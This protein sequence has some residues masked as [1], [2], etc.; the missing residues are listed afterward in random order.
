MTRSFSGGGIVLVYVSQG[1]GALFPLLVAPLIVRSSGLAEFGV[2]AILLMCA[3]GGALISE[4]SFDAYGPRLISSRGGCS[5][6]ASESFW[7][8]LAVKLV[9]IPFAVLAAIVAAGVLVSGEM[10][11]AVAIG[12]VLHVASV[13]AQAQWHLL[14]TNQP[15]LLAAASIVSRLFSLA[16][17]VVLLK[18]GSGG[19]VAFFVATCAGACFGAVVA[20]AF[21]R[22]IRGGIRLVPRM[23]MLIAAAPAFIGVA[24]SFVQNFVGQ[25]IAGSIGGPSGAGAFAAVDRIA[26]GLSAGLKPIFMVSY[27]RMA[28]MHVEEP[29]RGRRLVLQVAVCWLLI[30]PIVV[31]LAVAFGDELLLALYG[32]VM[33]GH[34]TLLAILVGWLCIGILNNVLG[35]QGILA[36]GWDRQYA[37]AMWLGILAAVTSGLVLHL[38][39]GLPGAMIA[40]LSV[41]AGEVAI[42]AYYAFWYMRNDGSSLEG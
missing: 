32:Q 14:S 29:V 21:N 23:E 12:I 7:D 16:A 33:S 41:L 17:I 13:A 15:Y 11:W 37:S 39:L 22:H 36:S 40:A 1:V 4:Y 27:P 34:E 31:F 28:R 20:V 10:G 5:L 3:Q 6:S 30:S 19:A 38:Q 35:I 26:R 42:A 18:V 8:I 2:Y 24:G 9:L 25:A